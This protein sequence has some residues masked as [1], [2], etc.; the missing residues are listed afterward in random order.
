MKRVPEVFDCWFESG[1]M[2]I[3]QSHYPFENLDKFNPDPG[4]FRKSVGFPAEFIGEGLDQ[5]RGWFYSMLVLSV[6]LFGESSYKNVIVNGIMLSEDGQ[7]LSKRLKNY[8][9]PMLLVDKYGADA[10][11]YC[12]LSSPLVKAEDVR[13]SE[14]GVDEVAKKILSRLENVYS[15]YEMYSKNSSVPVRNFIPVTDNVLD[16]WMLARL[17]KIIN[18][19]TKAADNY[20]LDRATRPISDFVDDLSTWYLRRSR[21]RFKSDDIKDKNQAIETTRFV[22]EEFA[23]IIAPIMPF[24]A[25]ELYQKVKSFD[26]KE[27]VHLASWP[28]INK[29]SK[30]E[31]RILVDMTEVRK[32]VSFGLEARSKSLIKVRQ[33]LLK[34]KVKEVKFDTENLPQYFELIKDEVNVKEVVS[35]NTLTEEV[36]LD[37]NITAELKEEGNVRELI[38]AIQELRKTEKLNPSDSVSLKIKTEQKGRDLVKKF[39]VEIKKTTLLKSVLFEEIEGATIVKVD[40]LTF[41]LRINK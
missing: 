10:L 26:G 9:D 4:L 30:D 34:L 7:K 8:P 20:E 32:I 18:E 33:P 25:E 17:N 39:E 15:F 31:D 12:L 27:S 6:A 36:E 28:V 38:R 40:D 29:L 22:L 1:S 5:T 23:K 13:F 2:P 3:S 24:Y 19:V 21:D 41:E 11:R 37:L 35:D 14:A 16:Q